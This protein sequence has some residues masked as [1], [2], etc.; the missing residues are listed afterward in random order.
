MLESDLIERIAARAAR[1]PGTELGVGDDAAV[2]ALDDGRAVVAQ[3]LL[4]EGV[5]FRL[6]TTGPRDLGHK[7]IA[8]N[9]S[10]LAAMG[11][12]PLAAFVGLVLPPAGFDDD[13]FDAL[14]DGMEALAGAHGVTVAGGDISAGGALTLAVTVIGCPYPGIE[15]LRRSGAGDGDLLCV[16]GPLGAAA[17]GL[18]ILER[19][20]LADGI[21]VADSLRDAQRRP[22]AR[23]AEGR[24]LAGHGATAMMDVSD[25]LAIDAER[26]ARASGLRA[27]VR[28]A[29]L[30]VAEGVAEVAAAAGGDPRLMALTGGEDYE[31]LVAI[32]PDR[33]EALR[34]L[35]EEPLTPLGH[36]QAGAPGLEVRDDAGGPVE[37]ERRGWLH[38]V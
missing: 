19:P 11:A 35:L 33:L 38:E 24:L 27:V 31:L 16:T 20:A 15:P 34:A 2:L 21:A 18:A 26:L 22:V 7:A 25:G 28:L 23:L 30:P 29:D 8:V 37:L 17:A 10:D 9:L 12:R 6:S 36:L 3:D 4:V 32:P 13:D 1:R 5:H 14:Y